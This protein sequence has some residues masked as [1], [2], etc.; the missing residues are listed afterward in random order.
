MDGAERVFPEEPTL[1]VA[2]DE[3]TKATLDTGR[4]VGEAAF[5]PPVFG[6]SPPVVVTQSSETA[7][8][9]SRLRRHRL[10]GE[11]KA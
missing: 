8:G 4:A 1:A 5:A 6:D 10:G 3:V 9:R 11:G 2:P 7:P